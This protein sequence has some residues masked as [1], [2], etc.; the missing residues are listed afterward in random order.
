LI[1]GGYDASRFV[2]NSASFTLGPDV[3]R[4][5]VVAVQSIVYSGTTQ[6]NLLEKPIIAFIE[7]TDPKEF[8][9]AF[10]LTLD[11]KSGLYIISGTHY[12]DLKAAGPEVTFTL[13]NGLSGGQTVNIVLPFDSFA[14]KASYPFTEKDTYYFP[15][16]KAANETQITLGRAFLQEA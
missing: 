15:L 6:T 12:A 8:E 1:F 2:T 14:L 9:K 11:K 3:S 4:D 16:R 7:S 5:I 10:G 13:A